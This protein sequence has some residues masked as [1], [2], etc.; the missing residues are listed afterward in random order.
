VGKLLYFLAGPG[1]L[2]KA[3]QFLMFFDIGFESFFHPNLQTETDQNQMII[4]AKVHSILCS[5]L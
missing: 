3:S 5:V 1:L 2:P 4:D